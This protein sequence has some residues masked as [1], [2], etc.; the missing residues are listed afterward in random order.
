MCDSN[1]YTIKNKI[2]GA[3]VH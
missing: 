2:D 1:N 3:L